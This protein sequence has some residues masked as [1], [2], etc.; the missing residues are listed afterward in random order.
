MTD[1]TMTSAEAAVGVLSDAQ[2]RMAALA[3]ENARLRE[4]AQRLRRAAGCGRH[5]RIIDRTHTDA[6]TLLHY[7]AA[8]LDVGRRWLRDSG[9]MSERRYGWAL[10]LLRLAR[11]DITPASIEHLDQCLRRVAASVERLHADGDITALRARGNIHIRR[12]W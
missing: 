10:A 12:R 5:Q 2:R 11:C 1:S 9:V 8:G 6:Q 4:E 3:A 7:R